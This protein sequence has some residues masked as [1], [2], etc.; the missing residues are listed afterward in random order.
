MNYHKRI[1]AVT[2]LDSNGLGP[3]KSKGRAILAIEA[4]AWSEL[5][6]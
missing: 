4:I 1:A 2:T 3:V 6:A 5:R